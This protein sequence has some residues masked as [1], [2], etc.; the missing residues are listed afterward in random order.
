MARLKKQNPNS[1]KTLKERI[2][3]L[4][5]SLAESQKQY[6]ALLNSP[7]SLTQDVKDVI[8]NIL[9]DEKNLLSA[10]PMNLST[11][12]QVNGQSS[13]Q[14]SALD[15]LELANGQLQETELDRI[16]KLE[17]VLCTAQT[18]P[19]GTTEFGIF[20]QN[21]EGMTM[22]SLQSLAQRVGVNPWSSMPEVKK[23]LKTAFV[24]T[25]SQ[26]TLKQ[27]PP[28]KNRTLNPN[29]PKDLKVMQLLGMKVA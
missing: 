4:E 5:L 3:F 14:P 8:K 29:D 9:S 15:N 28:T 7:P 27:R 22:A 23:D 20:E 13:E 18:N 10:Q 2:T 17:Q 6:S 16:K 21:L 26:G 24:H 1:P 12:E 19:F 25:N 11:L